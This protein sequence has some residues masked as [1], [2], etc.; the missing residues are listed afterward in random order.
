MA[1]IGKQKYAAMMKSRSE[2]MIPSS[3]LLSMALKKIDQ[4]LMELIKAFE[5]RSAI[6]VKIKRERLQKHTWT[7][8]PPAG[9]QKNRLIV[10]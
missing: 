6:M 2:K 4:H 3:S 10:S 7:Y 8:T 5:S 9:K 1:Q